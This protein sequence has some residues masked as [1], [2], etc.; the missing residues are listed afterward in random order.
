MELFWSIVGATVIFMVVCGII[1]GCM[2]EGTDMFDNL[3]SRVK[4]CNH[5]WEE[6]KDLEGY[7]T[8][9]LVCSKCGK[10]HEIKK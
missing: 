2:F 7:S 6:R 9:V 5:E 1:F 3:A 10:I 8:K 4:K